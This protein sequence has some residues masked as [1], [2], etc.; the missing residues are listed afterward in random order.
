V[1]TVLAPKE[2]KKEPTRAVPLTVE[3]VPEK[4]KPQGIR[5][6]NK[7]ATKLDKVLERKHN[8]VA[9]KVK[10][11]DYTIEVDVEKIKAHLSTPQGRVVQAVAGYFIVAMVLRLLR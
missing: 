3:D 7:K 6:K 10:I 9:Y 5:L 4:E 2:E 11:G 1:P 8:S